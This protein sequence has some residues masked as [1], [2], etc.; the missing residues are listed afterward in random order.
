MTHLDSGAEVPAACAVT[1]P[2]QPNAGPACAGTRDSVLETSKDRPKVVRCMSCLQPSVPDP[3]VSQ[4][5]A[6]LEQAERSQ[7]P[8]SGSRRVAPGR[9]QRGPRGKGGGARGRQ[10]RRDGRFARRCVDVRPS[11]VGAAV[12]GASGGIGSRHSD[13]RHQTPWIGGST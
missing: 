10:E 5:C 8:P 4:H 12:S 13:T 9:R 1:P 3:P 2:L 6:V 11:L 7:L